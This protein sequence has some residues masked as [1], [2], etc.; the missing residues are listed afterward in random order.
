MGLLDAIFNRT[1]R[2]VENRVANDVANSITNALFGNKSSKTEPANN[3]TSAQ[4]QNGYGAG[5][6][7]EASSQ[8]EYL[9]EMMD[10]EKTRTRIMEILTIHFNMYQVK[11]DVSPT[12][13]GGTGNFMNYTFGVYQSGKPVLF[14][15]LVGKSTCRTRL[16]RWSKEQAENSGVKMIN[17]VEH[18]PNRPE[19]VLNRLR[20][21]LG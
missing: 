14:I 18:Y 20:E 9:D 1:K 15:M 3:G 5:A 2:Q 10:Y 19:Y 13:L 11:T 4:S 17:F 6:Q 12:T 7:Q 16:Y 21:Y 8:E